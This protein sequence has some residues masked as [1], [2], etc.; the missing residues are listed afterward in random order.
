MLTY[1]EI[2]NGKRDWFLSQIKTYTEKIKNSKE[3]MVSPGYIG[4]SEAIEL[5]QTRLE[6]LDEIVPYE[7]ACRAHGFLVNFADNYKD[8]ESF[9][10]SDFNGFCNQFGVN[11]LDLSDE[12]FEIFRDKDP[13]L[14]STK[15]AFIQFINQKYGISIP[16]SVQLEQAEA[17]LK[18]AKSSFGM[19][20]IEYAEAFCR[21]KELKR[22]SGIFTHFGFYNRDL[23]DITDSDYIEA[24][25]RVS[26]SIIK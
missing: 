17:D 8:N 7:I 10:Y 18:E 13:S 9:Y 6:H 15:D 21:L 22:D 3:K 5:F 14:S 4:E 26:A 12:D 1:D 2:K 24:K 20:S 23:L 25:N 19:D 16:L 11:T